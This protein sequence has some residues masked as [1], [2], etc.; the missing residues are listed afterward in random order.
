MLAL[1][2]PG[3]VWLA[4]VSVAASRAGPCLPFALVA[5]GVL[6]FVVFLPKDVEVNYI[7]AGRAFAFVPL[8]AILALPLLRA[9]GRPGPRAVG[10]AMLL[11]SPVW[12][13][14]VSVLMSA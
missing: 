4:V 1:V 11:L 3:I 13:L 9:V 14:L 12:F 6:L 7:A 5:V 2:L 10:G 8:A